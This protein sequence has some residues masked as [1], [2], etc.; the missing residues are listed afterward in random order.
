VIYLNTSI[1]ST[2]ETR[3]LIEFAF[4]GVDHTCVAVW[5]KNSYANPYR[6]MA[7]YPVP[8]MSRFVSAKACKYLVT[9][10]LKPDNVFPV[11]NRA[12]DRHRMR[13]PLIVTDTWQELLVAV[14]AHEARHIYQFQFKKGGSEVDA[15]TYSLKMLTEF[16]ERQQV[17]VVSCP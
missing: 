7:Y 12:E 17:G 11:Y 8:S 3:A 16:R 9:L 15:E 5:L 14:S 1:Y 4:S 6:G 2:P 10:G 13:R